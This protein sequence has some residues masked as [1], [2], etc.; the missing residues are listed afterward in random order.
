M[1][2][3]W[4]IIEGHAL[5]AMRDLP[6][7]SV[8]CVVT[9]PPYWGL[10]DY[11]GPRQIWDG[12]PDCQHQWDAPIV[13][14]PKSGSK[15]GS[16]LE[17]TPPGDE[18]RPVWASTFCTQCNAWSGQ[19]GHEPTVQLYV[20]HL[21]KIFREIRRILRPDGTVWL[22]LGDSFAGSRKGR[23]RDMN[24]TGAY[25]YA[26]KCLYCGGRFRSKAQLKAHTWHIHGRIMGRT[27]GHCRLSLPDDCICDAG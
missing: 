16:T 24:K 25:G 20:L 26:N 27:C 2:A 22:N 15:K 4:E 5:D 14:Y 3:T 9:S 18:R 17:G 10:R 8:H 6:A 1:S 21:V 23:K 11:K 7:D 19:L 13:A 12:L